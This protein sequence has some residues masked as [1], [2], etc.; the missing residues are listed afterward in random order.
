MHKNIW[1][2]YKKLQK[3]DKHQIHDNGYIWGGKGGQ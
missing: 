1:E 3:N 2:N